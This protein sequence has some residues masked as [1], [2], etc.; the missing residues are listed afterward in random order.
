MK[1]IPFESEKQLDDSDALK[2]SKFK[3]ANAVRFA[4]KIEIEGVWYMPYVEQYHEH[5]SEWELSRLISIQ[6]QS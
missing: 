6:M 4:D 1:L 5:Y 2:L 3:D